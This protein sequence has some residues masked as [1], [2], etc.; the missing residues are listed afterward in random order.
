M[1]APVPQEVVEVPLGR[2]TVVAG[3]EEVTFPGV[4]REL[5][6][7]LPVLEDGE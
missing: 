2:E 1:N 3:P 5:E 7:L 6:L 4:P